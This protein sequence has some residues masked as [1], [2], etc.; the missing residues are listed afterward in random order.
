MKCLDFS[1]GAFFF[2]FF[3]FTVMTFFGCNE[4]NVNSL[5]AIQLKCISVNN[6]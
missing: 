2:F 5:N 1:K 3:F 6:Q 4:L